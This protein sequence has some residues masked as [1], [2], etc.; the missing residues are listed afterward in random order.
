MESDGSHACMPTK[1]LL[2]SEMQQH[3]HAKGVYLAD[4]FVFAMSV[5]TTLCAVYFT[6]KYALWR[7][8][9]VAGAILVLSMSFLK[10]GRDSR[11]VKKARKRRR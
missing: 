6:S 3:Y 2:T 4:L 11:V 8:N 1:F 10:H 5:R 9:G 7:P